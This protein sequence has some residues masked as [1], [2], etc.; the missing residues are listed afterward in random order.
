MATKLPK[1]L[2]KTQKIDPHISGVAGFVFA[3]ILVTAVIGTL[4]MNGKAADWLIG[5]YVLGLALI[6][7]YILYAMRVASQWEKAIILRLGRFHKLAGPGLFWIVPIL[8]TIPS[9]IDHR[10]MVTPFTAEKTLTKDTVPGCGR[11]PVLGCLGR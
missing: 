6:G 5:T 9:W 8:D 10:V 7:A 3:I 1:E 4:V 2:T 11:R